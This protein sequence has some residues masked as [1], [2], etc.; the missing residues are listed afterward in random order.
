[1]KPRRGPF[2]ARFPPTF[3]GRAQPARARTIGIN[4]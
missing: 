3:Y 4:L 1:M 2:H